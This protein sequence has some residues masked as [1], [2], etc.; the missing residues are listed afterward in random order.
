[1]QLSHLKL[2]EKRDKTK[3]S[4]KIKQ[5]LNIISIFVSKL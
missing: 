3:Y 5:A 4:H 1:M 2:D